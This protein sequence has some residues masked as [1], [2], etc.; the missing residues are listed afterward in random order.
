VPVNARRALAIRLLPLLD[1]TSLGEGDTPAQIEALCASARTV[2]GLPAALCVYPEHVAKVAT[3]VNFP[4]GGGDSARAVRETRR[5]LAAG[6][7]EID[8]VL[9]YRALRRGESALAETVVKACRDVCTDG[10]TLK[11]ILEIGELGTPELVRQACAIGLDARVDFLKTSTGKVAVNATPAAAAL[12]LDAIAQDGGRCGF[13][14]AGGIRT[15]ADAEV[16]LEL[17]ATRL[18]EDW[19]DPVHFRIGASTLFAELTA[20]LAELE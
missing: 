18:G 3:V 13:K 19:I 20:A 11:L 17:A 8:L 10:A 9:P 4:D 14:A 1:L 12:M 15:L 6:A 7:D 16:Y 5:A 2:Q